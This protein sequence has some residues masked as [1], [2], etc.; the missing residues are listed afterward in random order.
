M[1]CQLLRSPIGKVWRVKAPLALSPELTGTKC[2]IPTQ[3]ISGRELY[4]I[5]RNSLRSRLDH[6]RES[7]ACDIQQNSIHRLN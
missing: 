2:T 7:S 3:I 6:K 5:N 1:R 4:S